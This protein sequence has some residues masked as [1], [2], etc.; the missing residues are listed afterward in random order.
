MEV[1]VQVNE[2]GVR[3]Y[4]KELMENFLKMMQNGCTTPN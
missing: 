4:N 3:R 1:E 2:K